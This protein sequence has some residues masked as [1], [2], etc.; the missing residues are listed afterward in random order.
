[1]P[2]RWQQ[3]LRLLAEQAPGIVPYWRMKNGAEFYLAIPDRD[4]I[5]ENGFS[6]GV[7]FPFAFDEVASLTIQPVVGPAR[8]QITNDLDAAR[9][10]VSSANGLTCHELGGELVVR[11][12]EESRPIPRGAARQ[13]VEG[14]TA[15]KRRSTTAKEAATPAPHRRR[16]PRP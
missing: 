10:A 5:Q 7:E 6:Q 8:L 9:R 11:P 2:S 16:R 4:D 3:L 13:V 1:M 15:A 12:A 14:E